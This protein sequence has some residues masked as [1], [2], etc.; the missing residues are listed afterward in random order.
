MK[1]SRSAI[2]KASIIVLSVIAGALAARAA[3]PAWIQNIE[4]RSL[5][6]AA[7]FRTVTL[8]GG[9][10]AIRR[11]PSETVPALG[12]LIKQQPKQGELY[13]LKALEEEEKLDFTAAESDWKLYVQNGSDKGAADLALADFYHRRNRPVDEVNALSAAGRLPAPASERFTTTGEQRSW[14][15]FERIFG[16]I[17]AQALGK[18]V[19]IDQYNT[20]LERYP[21]EQGLYGRYFQYLL[22]QKDFKLAGDLI[23]RYHSKFP[24]DEIFPTRAHALLAYQQGSVE[25]GLAVYDKNFQP[26]WPAE[27]VKNYFD[28]LKETGS[29]RKFLDQ[30]RGALARNP[31]DLN[32][33]ARIFYYYQQQGNL[34]AAQQAITE[35]RLK[36]D[37]RK[38]PWTSQELY[39]FARLLEAVHFYPEAARYY[40]ALYNSSGNDA[41]TQEKALTGLANILLTAPEQPVRFGSGDISMYKDIATMDSGPGYLNGILSLLLNNSDPSAHYTEEQQRAVPYFHR[42]RAAELIAFLDQKIPNS[43]ARAELH[44]RLIEAYSRYAQDEAVV[45]S[46]REYLT[47][48]PNA[49][50]RH[51]VALLMADS[52]ARTNNTK[53]EFAIY[54]SMLQELARKADGIP[55]GEH[56]NETPQEPQQ[57]SEAQSGNGGEGD[58]GD[59][60]TPSKPHKQKESKAAFQV[61]AGPSVARGGPRSPE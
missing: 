31:D 2:V 26:L 5:L 28:L 61:N 43:P 49:A 55:L 10:T 24:S 22:D 57:S 40:F 47:A 58:E 54:D 11:P 41:S 53:E 8:P 39:T 15:A 29:L 38:A 14:T 34:D 1:L 17:D 42:A 19:A 6:E 59:G 12:D 51:Q 23:T 36:K 13:S 46:G 20:W 16:V 18:N 4:V 52:F 35:Y 25:Q 9:P 27:L 45:R 33:A 44:A 32:S 21:Q 50:Q 48:F 7:I 56:F 60:S 30:T 37:A 3:M